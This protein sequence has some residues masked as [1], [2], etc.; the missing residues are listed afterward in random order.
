MVPEYS[1]MNFYNSGQKDKD[2]HELCEYAQQMQ[3]TKRREVID[4]EIELRRLNKLAGNLEKE[5][6]I[7]LNS[8]PHIDTS[9]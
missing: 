2:I 6:M 4:K 1:T 3:K 7:K 9:R 5:L 8:K